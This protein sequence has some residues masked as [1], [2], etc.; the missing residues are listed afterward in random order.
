MVM[1]DPFV[2]LHR[3]AYYLFGTTD[4]DTGFRCYTS[5]NLVDWREGGYAYQMS[6]RCWAG[7]PFWA[8]EVRFHDNRFVMTYSG[9]DR[10]SGRLLVAMAV[11]D[12]PTG[13]Y[14]DLHA[15][16]FDA[17]YSAIDGHIFIDDDGQAY[18]FFSRNGLEDGIET[19]VICGARLSHDLSTLISAPRVLMQADQEWERIDFTRNRANEGPYV[20]KK[21]GRYFMM[22]SANHTFRPGYGIGY[23]TADAPLGPWRKSD[24][25][26]LAASDATVGYA[27]AGHNSVTTSPDGREMFIVYHTHADPAHPENGQRRVNIDRMEFDRGRLVIHGPTRSPQP[28]PSGSSRTT[29][30][31]GEMR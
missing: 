29:D 5:P 6:D 14:V 30:I 7:P 9:R 27:G 17:G 12:Q 23:A 25:N 11:S 24:D 13:P 2:L 3:G 20:L 19:G 8:P 21:G 4:P 15:P 16:L 18:F 31:H 22:Y 10:A 26:P 1:G 28:V